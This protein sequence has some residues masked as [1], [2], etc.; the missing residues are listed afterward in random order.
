MELL[1][2]FTSHTQLTLKL[3]PGT[4]PQLC[5][6]GPRLNTPDDA[7]TASSAEWPLLS[8]ER[9]ELAPFGNFSGESS[10]V[11][12]LPDGTRSLSLNLRDH[13]LEEMSDCTRL[14]L[15]LA[16]A[17]YPGFSAQL[18]LEA[19]HNEDTFA[20]R[21]ALQN[22]SGHALT[23]LRAYSAALRLKAPD[24]HLTAFRGAW[25]GE[26]YQEEQRIGRGLTVSAGSTS[27]IQNAQAGTPG[28][29]LSLGAPATET[30]GNCLLG[31]LCWSGNYALTFKHSDYGHLFMGMGHDFSHAPYR[32]EAAS[33]LE[34][35]QALLLY[36]SQ[37]KGHAS[38]NLHRHLRRHILPHGDQPRRCLLNSWEGVHFGVHQDTLIAMMQAS[39]KLGIELFVL[40]DGWFGRRDD[41]TSSLGDWAPAPHKL[42]Q[43]LAPLTREAAR[44]GIGFGLWVEPE[45]ISPDSDLYRAH[46]DWALR[47][48]T[49]TPK[50]ERHQLVLDLCNPAVEEHIIT[51]MTHLLKQNPGISYIK[52]DCNRKITDAASPYLPPHRQSNIFSDYIAAYNR[53]MGTLRRSFPDVTFQCCSAGGGRLDCGA[54]AYHEEFWLSD[55]TDAFERL[56][57][58][59]S[60]SF[61]FPANA[62]GC[63]VTS[64]PNLY[65]GRETPLK[66]RFDAALAGRLGLELDPRALT[67]EQQ[68]DFRSRLALAKRLRPIVQ[69]GDLYRLVSPY[70]GPDCALLYRRGSQALLLAYTTQRHFTHQ[71]TRIP[72]HGLDTGTRYRITELCPDSTGTRSPYHGLTLGSD[73]LMSTGIPICWNRPFQSCVLLLEA[74]GH[75]TLPTP[76]APS[77]GFHQSI[78][79]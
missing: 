14:I 78:P 44:L 17:T 1:H 28:F 67:P 13:H 7:A 32:L 36:S 30:T 45:M 76:D 61:F 9:D 4:P 68:E 10:L 15:T 18:T 12:Q 58:Q 22:N 5:Y 27:G 31:A 48:P 71:H 79:S 62:I 3:D 43:G 51:T 77:T 49:R 24:Y 63:H 46:P 60:A 57:M 52:W 29:I 70:E 74:E 59:W 50:Q 34:L 8:T 47:L 39:A 75:A 21:C 35:P 73:A 16:D 11:I 38:R 65:T 56:R 54:A 2:L 53:I 64:S 41:D 25:S 23:I 69:L 66:F 55:N 6:L 72:L 19:W 20:L 37:G 40:D 42:P 26:N 33:R